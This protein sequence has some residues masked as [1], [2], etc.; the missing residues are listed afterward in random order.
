MISL[1]GSALVE[2]ALAW[3]LTIETGS[4]TVLA[5]AVMVA[6]LPQIILGPFI[7]PLIDRWNRKRIMICADLAIALITVGLVVLFYMDAIQ[8]WHIYVAMIARAIGQAFHFPAMQATIPLIVPQ[9]TPGAHIGIDPD[10]PGYYQY[11]RAACRSVAFRAFTD[12]GSAI[13]RY[14]HGSY[15]YRMPGSGCHPENS[16]NRRHGRYLCNQGNDSGIPVYMVMEG[17]G[18][19]NHGFN[20]AEPVSYTTVHTASD[21]GNDSP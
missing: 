8:V 15:S 20:V 13:H 11:R 6:I 1:L 3:Y 2:F 10:V 19:F 4:A 7:G 18:N 21:N 16:K 17:F 9:K 5:T 14:Y 12:A